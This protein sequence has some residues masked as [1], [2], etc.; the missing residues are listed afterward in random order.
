VS[1]VIERLPKPELEQVTTEN[2]RYYLNPATGEKFDSVTTILKKADKSTILE[3]WK[4][5]VGEEVAEGISF[6][7]RN[8]GT[9][10]HNLM[11][12]YLLGEPDYLRGVDP[13]LLHSFKKL[14]PK[15]DASVSKVYGIELPLYS[16]KLN[17]AGTTDLFC[18]WKGEPAILDYKTSKKP[19]KA[20]WIR[21]YFI[22]GTSYAFMV[23]E[24]F[25]ILV[26]KV[27]IVMVVNFQEPIIFEK[28]IREFLPD[29][30]RIFIRERN[31]TEG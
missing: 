24:L 9:A 29:L 20:E 19:K 16:R 7:A 2:G 17:A 27:V 31:A 23:H 18:V 15:I 22:Q 1:F 5:R 10:L 11:E 4:K 13:I 3:D 25:N 26:P 30:K 21:N 12:R 14:K 8:K 6:Q 28:D